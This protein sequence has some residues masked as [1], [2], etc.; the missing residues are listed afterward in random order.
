MTP[1]PYCCK[2][3]KICSENKN[4]W[5]PFENFHVAFYNASFHP[6]ISEY[7]GMYFLSQNSLGW[8][9]AI[10]ILQNENWGTEMK[11]G[12]Q[13]GLS[14]HPP[15]S[16]F[17]VSMTL[18]FRA[19]HQDRLP[20][21]CSNTWLVLDLFFRMKALLGDFPSKWL[22]LHG[23]SRVEAR[24]D[25]CS[26]GHWWASFILSPPFPLAAPSLAPSLLT[27]A[28]SLLSP[29]L[30]ASRYSSNS[31]IFLWHKCL[32]LH[33]ILHP[34]FSSSFSLPSCS[35]MHWVE[36][37]CPSTSAVCFVSHWAHFRVF[38]SCDWGHKF[39]WAQ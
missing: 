1:I 37:L 17:C 5:F 24:V 18:H 20:T 30:P 4:F 9:G 11:Q 23:S 13:V 34:D 14:E 2:N 6:V 25:Y 19:D 8:R 12:T 22:A 16:H 33:V 35:S 31:S 39:K 7:P 27:A 32:W 10:L 3:L 38:C 29:R 15:R 28:S 21:C 26:A 36:E